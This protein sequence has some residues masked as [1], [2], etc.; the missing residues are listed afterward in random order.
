[1]LY[2][3]SNMEGDF[4][5]GN[6]FCKY[7]AD[8]KLKLIGDVVSLIDISELGYEIVTYNDD[9]DLRLGS[10]DQ[11]TAPPSEDKYWSGRIEVQIKRELRFASEEEFDWKEADAD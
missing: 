11:E 3:L 4:F 9:L 10:Y 5:V 7:D 8:V 2:A 6:R 1:M